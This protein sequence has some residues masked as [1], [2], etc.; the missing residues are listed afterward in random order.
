M[1]RRWGSGGAG[2]GKRLQAKKMN[3]L[4]GTAKGAPL[5]SMN[6]RELTV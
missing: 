2:A 3:L 5:T 4:K 6:D 1:Q